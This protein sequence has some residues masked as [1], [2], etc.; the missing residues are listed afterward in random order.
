MKTIYL[1]LRTVSVVKF[2]GDTDEV[3]LSF[4]SPHRAI[5]SLNFFFLFFLPVM[6][7]RKYLN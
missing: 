3:K 2:K 1:H 4:I 5:Y 6:P 7:R